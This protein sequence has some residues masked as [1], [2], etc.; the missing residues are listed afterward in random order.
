MNLDNLIVPV[1]GDFAGDTALAGIG[2]FLRQ[3]GAVVDVFYVSNVERYL[4]E[5]GEHGSNFYANLALLPTGADSLFIRS[6]TSDISIRLG[7]PIP[8]Q[9]VKWRTFLASI[10]E[11][12]ADVRSG[13]IAS[14]RDLFAR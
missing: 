1:V 6:V 11:D 2:Q 14:Y 9:P 4:W 5:Q 8:D 3:R 7:I 12:L 13:R 10:P